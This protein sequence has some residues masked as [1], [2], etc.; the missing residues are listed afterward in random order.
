MTLKH[1]IEPALHV[2]NICRTCKSHLYCETCLLFLLRSAGKT[3]HHVQNML[4]QSH[5]EGEGTFTINTVTESDQRK[6][7][8]FSCIAIYQLC[9]EPKLPNATDTQKGETG[10]Y[11]CQQLVQR[12]SIQKILFYLH[13]RL[14]ICYC[15]WKKKYD[16]LSYVKTCLTQQK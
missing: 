14:I 5:V 9:G 11:L 4:C 13:W 16:K 3:T 10:F 1:Y 15:G 7:T 2:K 6:E 8:S 12:Y